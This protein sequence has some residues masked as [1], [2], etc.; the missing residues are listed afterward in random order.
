VVRHLMDTL[1]RA[2]HITDVN[3]HE[4]IALTLLDDLNMRQRARNAVAHA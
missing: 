3:R 4:V 1:L 2:V